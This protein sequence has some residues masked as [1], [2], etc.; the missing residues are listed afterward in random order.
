V[1]WDRVIVAIVALLGLASAGASLHA[2]ATLADTQTEIATLK[3]QRASD[4]ESIKEMKSDIKD[5]RGWMLE[6]RGGR[7]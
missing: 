6:Q 1:S 7:R 2:R 4:L 5:I 3:A